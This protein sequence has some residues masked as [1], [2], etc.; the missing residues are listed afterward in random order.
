SSRKKVPSRCCTEI[1]DKCRRESNLGDDIGRPLCKGSRRVISHFSSANCNLKNETR[2]EDMY[3]T[4][5]IVPVGNGDDVGYSRHAKG[6][7]Y[8]AGVVAIA[9]PCCIILADFLVK[10]GSELV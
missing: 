4:A 8:Y 3:V 7:T 9:K 6:R 1:A 10:F 5:A 2:T